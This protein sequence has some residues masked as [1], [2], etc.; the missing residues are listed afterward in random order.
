MSHHIISYY[1][2]SHYNMLFDY[3]ILYVD[4]IFVLDYI[5][6]YCKVSY[7]FC[8]TKL[9]ITISYD[10][11]L[12][13]LSLYTY[14][15]IY[16]YIYPYHVSLHYV[17][18]YH[19]LLYSTILVCFLFSHPNT[20]QKG[21]IFGGGVLLCSTIFS[22][23]Y[24]VLCYGILCHSTLQCLPILFSVK[25]LLYVHIY[26]QFGTARMTATSYR[27]DKTMETTKEQDM[28]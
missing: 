20:R 14:T 6:L 13:S 23:F 5:I 25:E 3:M 7:K 17:A 24:T 15:Y 18:F 12:Y 27:Q 9:Y 26:S 2:L 21:W 28:R 8:F 1:I 11:I 19:I 10:I 4:C 16:I 22:S